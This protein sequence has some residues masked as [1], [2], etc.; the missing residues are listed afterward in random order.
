MRYSMRF[1]A[2]SAALPEGLGTVAPA[3]V[4]GANPVAAPRATEETR[5]AGLGAA[6]GFLVAVA[7]SAALW[8]AIYGLS[9]L[10]RH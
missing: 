7:L 1:A 10:L 2:Q 8:A 6:R 3:E 5:A 4:K 9:A